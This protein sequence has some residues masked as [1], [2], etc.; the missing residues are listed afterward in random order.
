MKWRKNERGG[1]HGGESREKFEILGGFGG[2]VSGETWYD[3]S[4]GREMIPQRNYKDDKARV[5]TLEKETRIE[6]ESK[7]TGR[8]NPQERGAR[9]DKDDWGRGGEG[10]M[11]G[12]ERWREKIDGSLQ[13][14][15][16]CWVMLGHRRTNLR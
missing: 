5:R 1:G 15:A 12:E 6:T 7:K 16:V 3:D 11:R 14:C 13:I 2:L 10:R 9:I 8:Q 4:P